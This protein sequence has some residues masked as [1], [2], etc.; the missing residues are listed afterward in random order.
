MG[1]FRARCVSE[2]NNTSRAL[3]LFHVSVVLHALV[4]RVDAVC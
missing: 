4:L 1:A 2:A 3:D